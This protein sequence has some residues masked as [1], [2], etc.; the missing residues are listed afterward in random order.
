MREL[1]FEPHELIY[2]AGDTADSAFI[3]KRGDVEIATLGSTARPERLGPGTVF[4]QVAIMLDQPRQR[5]ARALSDVV[6]LAIPR[7]DFLRAFNERYDVVEPFLRR[8]FA[9]LHDAASLAERGAPVPSQLSAEMVTTNDPVPAGVAATSAEAGYSI[10]IMAASEEAAR[11]LGDKGLLVESLPFRVGRQPTKGESP[12]VGLLDLSLLDAKPFNLSR[13]HFVIEA[14]PDSPFVR[15]VGSHLGTIVNS[16]K[17]GGAEPI[18]TAPLGPGENSVIAGRES[19]PFAFT[20]TVT[21][22]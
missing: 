5:T 2:R 14:G 1:H 13:R 6:V 15:D 18:R 10:R 12:P 11:H 8:L 17:I 7:A 9:T 20:I 19:S 22:S 4:G 16:A 21:A 3:I